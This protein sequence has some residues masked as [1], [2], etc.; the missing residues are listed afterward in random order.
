V[1]P[2]PE[3]PVLQVQ[4]KLP[5]LFVQTAFAEH[6]PLLVEH[7]FISFVYLIVFFFFNEENDFFFYHYK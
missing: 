2:F 7:S 6:P 4:L 5:T 1:T 3:Y